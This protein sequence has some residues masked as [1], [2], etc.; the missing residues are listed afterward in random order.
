MCCCC[1]AAAAAAAALLCGIPIPAPTGG[2]SFDFGGSKQS[3]FGARPFS[4]FSDLKIQCN[5][6]TKHTYVD[7]PTT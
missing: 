5:G 1:R 7:R 3:F 6:A 2:K 4:Q